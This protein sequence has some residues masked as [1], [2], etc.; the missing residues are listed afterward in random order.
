MDRVKTCPQGHPL[1]P[2]NCVQYTTY[3]KGYKEC[4]RC[5]REREYAKRARQK[6][7]PR[8]RIVPPPA[9]QPVP[10]FTLTAE[11]LSRERAAALERQQV[12]LQG[13]IERIK[14]DR[15]LF[16]FSLRRR[17][18]LGLHDLWAGAA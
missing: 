15:E 9:V 12:R 18:K 3:R 11:E 16:P 14:R 5:K 1:T 17:H 4:K 7:Q 6:I 13:A 8:A 2:D 10:K